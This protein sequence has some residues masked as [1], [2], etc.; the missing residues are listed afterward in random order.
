MRSRSQRTSGWQ[1]GLR[2]MPIA[3]GYLL[4]PQPTSS[5]RGSLI[6]TIFQNLQREIRLVP[7]DRQRRAKAYRALPGAQDQ[8]ASFEGALDDSV[9]Q[10]GEGLARLLVLDQLDGQHQSHS[11]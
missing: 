2:S 9:A 10:V 6:Q 3:P 5:V 8:Q 1:S 4:I 7:C 11:S